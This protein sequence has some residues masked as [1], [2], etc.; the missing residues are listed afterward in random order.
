MELIL[1]QDW[2][3]D[4]GESNYRIHIKVASDS[5]SIIKHRKL[6][7]Y[8]LRNAFTPM[9]NLASIEKHF[10]EKLLW[11]SFVQLLAKIKKKFPWK[12]YMT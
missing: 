7:D 2:R 9:L 10:S 6:T 11:H 5:L 1:D 12:A 3:D 4:T 8:R